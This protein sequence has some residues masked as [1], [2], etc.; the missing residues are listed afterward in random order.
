MGKRVRGEIEYFVK[1]QNKGESVFYELI[2]NLNEKK[3]AIPKESDNK[4]FRLVYYLSSGQYIKFNMFIF[5]PLNAVIFE[6]ISIN[7]N[8]DGKIK[9]SIIYR[10]GFPSYQI[11]KILEDYNSP[12]ILKAIIQMMPKFGKVS[13]VKDYQINVDLENII[14]EIDK[15]IQSLKP[16][17]PDL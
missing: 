5:D 9:E 14:D 3:F 4:N 15:Y 7:V 11:P 13:F 16:E 6:L 2:F 17:L 8:E 1:S 10:N 12:E